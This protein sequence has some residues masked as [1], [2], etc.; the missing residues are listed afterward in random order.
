MPVSFTRLSLY[1]RISYFRAV[2][3][4]VSDVTRYRNSLNMTTINCLPLSI[5]L[6]TV[7]TTSYPQANHLSTLCDLEAINT[8]FPNASIVTV[9]IEIL[10]FVQFC[11]AKLAPNHN[12]MCMLFSLIPLVLQFIDFSYFIRCVLCTIVCTYISLECFIHVNCNIYCQLSMCNRLC[13]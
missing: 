6:N 13:L 2:H 7:L 8:L 4:D 12:R 3:R 5:N 10:L 11:T 9:S 1:G